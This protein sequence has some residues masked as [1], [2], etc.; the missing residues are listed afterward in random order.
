[1]TQPSPLDETIEE[2][3]PDHDGLH[4]EERARINLAVDK[5]FAAATSATTAAALAAQ[6]W[7]MPAGSTGL[8]AAQAAAIASIAPR[9]GLRYTFLWNG[10]AFVGP[11]G[12]GATAVNSTA[13]ARV[14]AGYGGTYRDYISGAGGPDPNA[15]NLMVDGDSWDGV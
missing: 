4:S 1:M 14:T 2:G 8:S 5:A 11:D 9:A 3:Q 10:S 15:L 6:K 7:T 13:A 12:Q